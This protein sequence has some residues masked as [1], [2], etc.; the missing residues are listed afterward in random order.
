[1]GFSF[2]EDIKCTQPLTFS[3]QLQVDGVDPFDIPAL[4]VQCSG[5]RISCALDPQTDYGKLSGKQAT[6]TVAGVRD[7]ADNPASVARH[8]FAFQ[9]LDLKK[10]KA[11]VTLQT[12]TPFAGDFWDAN[13]DTS[14]H[15]AKSL[16]LN[17][18]AYLGVPTSRAVVVLSSTNVNGNVGV[19]FDFQP[20]AAPDQA[21]PSALAQALTS[22]HFTHNLPAAL[23]LALNPVNPVSAVAIPHLTQANAVIFTK[24]RLFTHFSEPVDG[25][26]EPGDEISAAFNVLLDCSEPYA[27]SIEVTLDSQALDETGY[28]VVCQDRKIQLSLAA[29]PGS[30]IANKQVTV[31]LSNV[32]SATGEVARVPFTWSFSMGSQFALL[33][34]QAPVLL[35]IPL[36]ISWAASYST[37]TNPQ[38]QALVRT[39]AAALAWAVG[40]APARLEVQQF[41][42]SAKLT[43]VVLLRIRPVASG[44]RRRAANTDDI[45]PKML[46]QQLVD[47]FNDPAALET[48][49]TSPGSNLTN[50]CNSTTQVSGSS[51]ATAATVAPST[52]VNSTDTPSVCNTTSGNATIEAFQALL[53][54]V[55][56]SEPIA[57]KALAATQAS[58]SPVSSQPALPVTPVAT[59]TLLTAVLVLCLTILWQSHGDRQRMAMTESRLL[60]Q[61]A[62][63]RE[64]RASDIFDADCLRAVGGSRCWPDNNDTLVMDLDEVPPA[65]TNVHLQAAF[66]NGLLKQG[67]PRI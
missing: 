28:L 17:I 41:E 26:F 50:S 45:P 10:M 5:P 58:T 39:I 11:R 33:N 24:P 53:R 1:M 35:S 15:F 7:L 36:G 4:Q 42:P 14:L 22:A 65:G 47:L 46:A 31:Q 60:N 19:V 37:M 38:T 55:D 16:L 18:T 12:S 67:A 49:L 23:A 29:L 52:T 8:T 13:S 43:I 59:L 51:N 61:I 48:V 3:V 44:Q 30:E 40:V 62:L 66:S 21:A 32:R 34:D 56:S 63:L 57:I 25:L 20:V 6:L 2:T 27:F 64:A 54:Q 9:K